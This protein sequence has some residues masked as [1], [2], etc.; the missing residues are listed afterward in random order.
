MAGK[1][2]GQEV[3][4]GGQEGVAGGEVWRARRRGREVRYGG[5]EGGAGR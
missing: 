1:R 3:R 4:Y 2:E 5:Q